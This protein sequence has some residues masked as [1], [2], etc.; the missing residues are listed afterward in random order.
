MNFSDIERS[1]SDSDSQTLREKLVDSLIPGFAAECDPE[2][3]QQ[4]GAFIEDALSEADAAESSID[5]E[6][7]LAFHA[8]REN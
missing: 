7:A 8:G 3:A 5:L 1:G 4:A 2:E 6:G